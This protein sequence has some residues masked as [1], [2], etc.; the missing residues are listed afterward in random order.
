MGRG[1]IL[2]FGGVWGGVDALGD[3]RGGWR[4]KGERGR[5]GRGGGFSVFWLLIVVSSM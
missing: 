2:C 3:D 4:K 1:W 5:E